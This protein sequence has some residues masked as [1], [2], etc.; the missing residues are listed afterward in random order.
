MGIVNAV[1]LLDINNEVNTFKMLT[2]AVIVN[3]V[4]KVLQMAE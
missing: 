3:T 1:L 2:Y 4:K